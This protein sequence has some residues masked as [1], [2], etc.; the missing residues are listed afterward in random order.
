APRGVGETLLAG[1]ERCSALCLAAAAAPVVAASAAAVA[2]ISRRSPFIAHLRLGKDGSSLWV[3]KV[4]TMWYDMGDAPTRM[5]WVEWVVEEP[6]GVMKGRRDPRIVSRFAAFLR[7]HSI[8]E[9]PQLWQVVR[10][11]MSL[12]GPRAMTAGEFQK[13]YEGWADDVL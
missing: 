11:E 10:G 3:W 12:I 5:S 6:E 1:L 9:L 4:R 13:H 8:D 2:L 7:K